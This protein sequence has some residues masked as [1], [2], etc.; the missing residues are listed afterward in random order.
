MRRAAG[1]LAGMLALCLVTVL[2]SVQVFAMD[3]LSGFQWNS[4]VL[5]VFGQDGDDRVSRQI[6]RFDAR[7][8]GLSDRDLTVIRI[9]GRDASVVF[10]D[11][12]A[13]D[14]DTLRR[15]AGV[16]DGFEIVLIGK[17]GGVKYRSKVLV[18]AQEI[19]ER[20]DSMP[21]RRAEMDELEQK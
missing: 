4:R 17:D 11:A 16:E 21:M 20:I 7:K 18:D 13:P 2:T 9:S 10:G 14:A 1:V 8:S 3:S 15:E 19:F 12:A 6:D 5:L